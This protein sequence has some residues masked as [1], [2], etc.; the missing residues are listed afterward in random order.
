MLYKSEKTVLI[1]DHIMKTG[2]RTLLNL[3]TDHFD[4][5]Y[6]IDSFTHWK[7]FKDDISNGKIKGSLAL[8]GHRIRGIHEYISQS[9]IYAVLLRDPLSRFL[10]YY[11][12]DLSRSVITE[13]TSLCDFIKIHQETTYVNHFGNGCAEK[14]VSSLVND[15]SIIGV[16]ENY[17]G[18]LQE[19]RDRFDIANTKLSKTNISRKYISRPSDTD[20]E[21]AQKLLIDDYAIYERA[22]ELSGGSGAQ[23]S[24][25]DEE[26][27]GVEY[28]ESFDVKRFV[29]N[30]ETERNRSKLQ[31]LVIANYYESEGDLLRAEEYHI[32][33]YSE[34][35]FTPEHLLGFYMRHSKE[36]YVLLA[37]KLLK[38]SA[39]Y[40]TVNSETYI[41]RF[42]NSLIKQVLSVY[43][44]EG[45][46]SDSMIDLLE[47]AVATGCRNIL[48]DLAYYIYSKAYDES[49]LKDER[50]RTVISSIFSSIFADSRTAAVFG[51]AEAADIAV[52]T[53]EYCGL[54]IVFFID[55]YVF[56][57]KNGKRVYSWDDSLQY[58]DKADIIIKGPCQKGY[59]EERKGS[60][61]VKIVAL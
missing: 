52:C 2:G 20:I 50:Y 1:F 27:Q 35:I 41:N 3:L 48:S 29:E 33:Y 5:F 34:D 46:S 24:M 23:V 12:F 49:F 45:C 8:A 15:Y 38:G 10:S 6:R 54:D 39:E 55:D 43:I 28:S 30:G 11:N 37:E 7:I 22:K 26:Y 59:P 19:L 58:I 53:A 14:A 31:S 40:A 60:K 42:V 36:K 32:K 17:G 47:T 56:G 21:N 16:T 9:C 4:N 61:T 18:F 51:T 13:E 57:E 44:T 25:P